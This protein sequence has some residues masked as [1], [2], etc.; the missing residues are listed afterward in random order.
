VQFDILAATGTTAMAQLLELFVPHSLALLAVLALPAQIAACASERDCTLSG[1][2]V[3]E[4]CV[5]D[6]PWTGET[7]SQLK[8]KPA[9]LAAPFLWKRPNWPGKNHFTWG[10]APFPTKDGRS[11]FYFTWL[12]GWDDGNH[13]K[14]V[15]TS[16]KI[17][18]SLGIACA[19][20][21]GGPYTVEKPIAFPF[22]PGHFDASYNENPV[23]TYSHHDSAYLM[24]YTTSP[25]SV[26]RSTKNWEGNGG[27][28]YIG[29]AMSKDPMSAQ[30]ERLNHTIMYPKPD[31]FEKNIAINAAVL[32]YP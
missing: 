4:R 14:P 2:C 5:C 21:I 17:S 23:I 6:K 30:W 25:A 12:T 11:C 1:E 3:A 24:A 15:P 22:R 29:F 13:T 26:S 20:T 10:A 32:T 18:G 9:K 7:C 31:G 16:D 27:L 8:L 28:Q 19:P